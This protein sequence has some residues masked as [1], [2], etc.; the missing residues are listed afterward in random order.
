M[1][2]DKE[3]CLCPL[4]DFVWSTTLALNQKQYFFSCRKTYFWFSGHNCT[5]PTFA[6]SKELD[7][8]L[9]NRKTFRRV[10]IKIQYASAALES[11]NVGG[12]G[13]SPPCSCS[14]GKN[15]SDG[16][17]AIGEK[18]GAEAK[19]KCLPSSSFRLDAAEVLRSTMEMRCGSGPRCF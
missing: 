17:S 18:P 2:T 12:S 13:T 11:G 1:L 8:F 19:T 10:L 14:G 16:S 6:I 9:C 15:A 3:T 4:G 7:S 5:R